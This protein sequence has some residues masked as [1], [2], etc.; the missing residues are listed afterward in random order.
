MLKKSTL[1]AYLSNDIEVIH[2]FVLC[3]CLPNKYRKEKLLIISAVYN[4]VDIAEVVAPF[5]GRK[6]SYLL[7]TLGSWQP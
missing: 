6:D 5:S 7:L 1:L 4:I 3:M 2:Y